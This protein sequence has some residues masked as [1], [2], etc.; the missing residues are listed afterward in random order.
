MSKLVVIKVS[1]NDSQTGYIE[2]HRLHA[3][4]LLVNRSFEDGSGS[5]K[6]IGR[7]YRLNIILFQKISF[8]HSIELLCT[9]LNGIMLKAN[10]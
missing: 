4:C 10:E 3:I 8:N 9:R 1:G 5:P 2:L 6:C 7:K